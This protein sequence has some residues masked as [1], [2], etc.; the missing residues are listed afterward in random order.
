M[1][2]FKSSRKLCPCEQEQ[3]ANEDYVSSSLMAGIDQPV[4]PH[5]ISA[6]SDLYEA[7]EL[8]VL[9]VDPNCNMDDEYCIKKAH[10]ALEKARGNK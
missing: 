8:M 7:L 6:A 4:A 10:K 3:L 1:S 2:G 9:V 5:I